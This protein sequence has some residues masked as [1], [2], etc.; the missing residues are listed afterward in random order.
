MSHVTQA[1]GYRADLSASDVSFWCNEAHRFVL[2][3][4]PH[5]LA[6]AIAVSSTSTGE[7]R[8]TLP[9]DFAEPINFSNL[10]QDP[11]PPLAPIN[12]DEAASWTTQTGTPSFYLLFNNWLELYPTPDSAYSLQ[13][14]YRTKL[15]EMTLVS[16]QPSVA[17]RFHYAVFC[18][19]KELVSRHLLNDTQLAD[20]AL[21]EYER[22]MAR[23][24]SDRIVRAREQ[25][26]NGLSLARDRTQS[27]SNSNTLDFDH[28]DS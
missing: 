17:T 16:A 1:V 22:Y 27:P 25:R 4:M 3:A 20:E 26:F 15:S 28:S 9:T 18:K 13:L 14:R 7:N 11:P 5:D 8:I 21:I 10:S 24:A 2:D 6:E 12:P 19:S 23:T